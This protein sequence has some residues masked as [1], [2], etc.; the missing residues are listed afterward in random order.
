M[1]FLDSLG[2]REISG[3]HVWGRVR[4]PKV[5]TMDRHDIFGFSGIYAIFS[6]RELSR[7]PGVAIYGGRVRKPN[8]LIIFHMG[9][10][11][12]LVGIRIFLV[13]VSFRG[14]PWAFGVSM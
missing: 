5:L 2:F 4:Y 6:F 14:P 12:I 13:S 7:A 8:V 9:D 1:S 3:S 10:I 11:R